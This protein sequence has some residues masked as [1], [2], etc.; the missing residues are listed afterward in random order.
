LWSPSELNKAAMTSVIAALGGRLLTKL[1]QGTK[2]EILR[3][4]NIMIQAAFFHVWTN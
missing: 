2:G 3:W 1:D 4:F